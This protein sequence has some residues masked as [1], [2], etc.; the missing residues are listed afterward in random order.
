MHE[1][2]IAT[3]VLDTVQRHAGGRRVLAVTVREGALRQVVPD[4]LSFWW[5]IV[6]RD[7][8]AAGSDLEQVA[9]PARLRCGEC[10]REW[11]LDMPLFRCEVCGTAAE[12]GAGNELEVE[13]I[14]VEDG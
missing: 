4:S 2:A 7:T 14:E 8:V 3:A 11:E 10:L 1:M 13:S 9:V 5:E 6:T 12:I